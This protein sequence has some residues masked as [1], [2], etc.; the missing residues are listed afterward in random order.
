MMLSLYLY[1]MLSLYNAFFISLYN[2][3][4]ISLYDT[5]LG[6][7][8]GAAYILFTKAP[9]DGHTLIYVTLGSIAGMFTGKNRKASNQVFYPVMKFCT[10][11]EKL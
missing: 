8:S 11:V 6:T 4:F 9:L 2:A 7:A 10:Q 1:M 3:F 5:F